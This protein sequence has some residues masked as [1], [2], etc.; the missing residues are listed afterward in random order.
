VKE[1]KLTLEEAKTGVSVAAIQ[2]TLG[3][4]HGIV[5]QGLDYTPNTNVINMIRLLKQKAIDRDALAK[6]RELGPEQ[7][8]IYNEIAA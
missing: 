6:D 8:Q 4:Y 2:D 3:I 7:L 1:N 5:L